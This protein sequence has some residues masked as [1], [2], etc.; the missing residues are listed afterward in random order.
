MPVQPPQWTDFLSCPICYTVFN[1]NAHKPISLACGHTMCKRCLAT[2]SK[3]QCPFDQ[4]TI[5]RDVDELPVNFALLQLVGIEISLERDVMP[6]NIIDQYVKH[7]AAAKK[8]VEELALYLKPLGKGGTTVG[9]CALSRPMQRKL[10]ALLNCQLVEDEGRSRALRAARSLGERTVTE[11]ILQH[12]N[13][14]QLSANLWAAVRGRGC[15]FLGP[16]M[17]EETLKLV[18]LALEDGTALSRKVLVLFV[19]QRLEPQFPQAS[20]TSVGHVVQLLYRASCFKVTK[21]D[22][23]S[24]LMQLKEEFR[25]YE[26]LRREHDAQIVQIA[27]EAGLRI[28]PEQWSSL[29]YG[30]LNHKSHMQSIIDKLQTPASFSSSINELTIALQRSGDPGNL[31]SLQPHLEYLAEI[32]GS[33]EG[34]CPSWEECENAMRAVKLIV[35]G[36]V[37]FA[38]NFS[39]T[40][41]M[42]N[43]QTPNVTFKTTMCRDIQKGGCP[44]GSNCTFAHSDKERKE[45][46]AESRRLMQTMTR[47]TS[48]SSV[49]DKLEQK[50]PL[51]PRGLGH[52]RN[53][54]SPV[55]R[56]TLPDKDRESSSP[57]NENAK[58]A[59]V[60]GHNDGLHSRSS[61]EES[62]AKVYGHRIHPRS[63]EDEAVPRVYGHGRHL[64]SNEDDSLTRVYGHGRHPSS[65]PHIVYHYDDQYY[66]DAYSHQ[67][68]RYAPVRGRSPPHGPSHG[69]PAV[70]GHPPLG[71]H[72]PVHGQQPGPYRHFKNGPYEAYPNYPK[73]ES[74]KY[75]PGYHQEPPSPDHH[76]KEP[77]HSDHRRQEPSLTDHQLGYYYTSHPNDANKH[78]QQPPYS[79]ERNGGYSGYPPPQPANRGWDHH[80]YSR[81]SEDIAAIGQDVLSPKYSSTERE[82]L[83]DKMDDGLL[84]R[85]HDLRNR[86]DEFQDGSQREKESNEK[87]NDGSEMPVFQSYNAQSIDQLNERQAAL[88]GLLSEMTP[89]VSKHSG[90]SDS[91]FDDEVEPFHTGKTPRM[92]NH[93]RPQYGGDFAQLY[94]QNSSKD[95]VMFSTDSE[96]FKEAANSARFDYLPAYEM[97]K[98]STLSYQVPANKEVCTKLTPTLSK[99]YIRHVSTRE[100]D[101]APPYH[102]F[103][104]MEKLSLNDLKKEAEVKKSHQYIDHHEQR[105]K[106]ML[107]LEKH[108]ELSPLVMTS[109][110]LVSTE[111]VTLNSPENISISKIEPISRSCRTSSKISGP[112]QVSAGKST[113]TVPVKLN[114]DCHTAPAL[115][116]PSGYYSGFAQSPWA[117]EYSTISFGTGQRFPLGKTDENEEEQK[118]K[119]KE[120]LKFVQNQIQFRKD[121]T[122]IQLLDRESRA[123]AEHDL[124][125]KVDPV[126]MENEQMNDPNTSHM[127]IKDQANMKPEARE[128][129]VWA[130]HCF[131]NTPKAQAKPGG[132]SGKS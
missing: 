48:Q 112:V 104:D 16:A 107:Q 73:H 51:L 36:F 72:S 87:R 83:R 54:T 63:N 92:P 49:G 23:D 34:I 103:H 18:L 98:S 29:L 12:Q 37:E 68:Y 38:Q 123:I 50:P 60:V 20:K 86:R 77:P 97:W 69:V 102:D 132:K 95:S 70:H 120:E 125:C 84:F 85:E 5:Q 111:P 129:L 25:N 33:T 57:S 119:I 130:K 78:R 108:N 110:S 90:Q 30:D 14:Q 15:Q 117:T 74:R 127:L 88:I 75:P 1:E 28:S 99:T 42:M 109:T 10:V 82:F 19:V 61:E 6:S 46:R 76:R 113:P 124:S 45:H 32:D 47:Q 11:L 91:I 7:Y 66:Y 122:D 3:K 55:P 64:Q 53:I 41:K 62:I 100:E 44:R 94:R 81:G 131:G 40:R 93:Q 105:E 52:A 80:I 24:S 22:A 43:Q 39:H 56:T 89:N 26:A 67:G 8:C 114:L 116:E 9:A 71:R 79:S 126:L 96:D 59:A 58:L 13:P 101:P 21:R 17:Q 65:N 121:A 115:Q 106:L 118:R 2:L 4:A 31:K 27:M 35:Q 128:N